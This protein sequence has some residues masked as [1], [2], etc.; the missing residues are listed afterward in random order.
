[1]TVRVRKYST[2]AGG[3]FLGGKPHRVTRY[4]VIWNG[5]KAGTHNTKAEADKHASQ[6]REKDRRLAAAKRKKR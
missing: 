6:L 2:I 5:T 4:D 1:M 3:G